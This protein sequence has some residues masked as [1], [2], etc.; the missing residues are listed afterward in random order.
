MKNLN[1]KCIIIMF[2]FVIHVTYII[3]YDIN[4][5]TITIVNLN[6]FYSNKEM[7]LNEI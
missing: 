5:N 3:I 1:I 6:S 2:I 4:E 7:K